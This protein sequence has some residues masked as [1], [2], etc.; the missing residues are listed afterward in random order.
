[1]AAEKTV[2]VARHNPGAC[3]IGADTVVTIG[4]TILG[5]PDSREHALEMLQKLCN[6][7]HQVITGLAITCIEQDCSLSLARTTR[8]SFGAFNDTVLR[9]YIATGEPMDKA[10]AYGI[11]ARGAFLVR[12]IQGSCSNVIGLPV[13]DCV[14]LLLENGFIRAGR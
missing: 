11:Q 14:R 8:V 9:A 5:K 7:T 3:V 6:R 13:N 2:A 4:E 1:M 12:E 10:G